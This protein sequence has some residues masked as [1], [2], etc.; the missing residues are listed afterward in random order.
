MKKTAISLLT[1]G[2]LAALASLLL[3]AGAASAATPSFD[4]Y[5]VAGTSSTTLPDGQSVNVWGYSPTNAPVSVPG[6]PTLYANVGDT[7]T[8]TLHNE[9]GEKTALLFQGQDMAPDL[10]GV[11]DGDTKVYTLKPT[12]PGTYLYEA[13]LTNNA[14]HQVAMGLYGA[15]VVRP[16]TAGQAYG[17]A[18]AYD[19]E[20]VLVL[21]E[22][23]PAL[24]ASADP[25]SFD[26]R[27]YSPKYFL[28][29]GK[30]Y[31]STAE[32][33]TAAGNKVLLRYVNAGQQYH[34]MAVLGARQNLVALDGNPLTYPR[35]A[36]AET[37]GPG[38]TADTILTAPAASNRQ[39]RLAVYDGSLLLHNSN[40]AGYG[41]M[42]TYVTIPS[43]PAP[44]DAGPVT[45]A[46]AYNGT[47][48]TATVVD[49]GIGAG[50]VAGAEY[51]V[52]SV[53]GT[54]V[55]M[56]AVDGTFD[57]VSENVTIAGI[58]A[59][60]HILYV[61]GKDSNGNLGVFSSVLVQGADT[62]GP[63]TVNATLNPN[64]TN[65]QTDVIVHA[66]ADD[67]ASG[68]SAVFAA[69][70]TIDAG[71]PVGMTVN[72]AAPIASVDGV[73]PAGT[74]NGLSP[75][76]H[77]VSI[78][79]RDSASTNW[80]APVT[81]NLVVDKTAPTTTIVSIAPN[82]NNGTKPINASTQAV[83][84]RVQLEDLGGATLSRAEAFIDTVGANGAGIVVAAD[85]GLF[86]SALETGYM[87]IPLTTVIQLSNGDHTI[88]V[89]AK[90]SAGNWGDM[91]TTT[92]TID[93]SPPSI[94][95]VTAT[96]NPTGTAT[97]VALAATAQADFTNVV[98]AEWFVG[99][100]PG[101][102]NGQAMAVSGSGPWSLSAS[103][104]VASW[105]PGS[106]SLKVRARDAAGNW[107]SVGTAALTVSPHP[108]SGSLFFS[109][110]G[111]ASLPGLGGTPDDADIYGWSGAAYSRA[112]DASAVGLPGGANV[113]A[114]HRV[115]GSHFYLSFSASNTSVPGLGNVQDEDVVYFNNGIWSVFF[116]GTAHGLT[117]TGE[118]ID[119]ITVDGSTLYFSTLGNVNPPNVGGGA[120]DADIYS[121]NGS[122]YSRVWDA[123]ANGLPGNADVDG[124]DR[125]DGSHLY[126][127]FTAGS[128]AVPSLGSVQDE[129]VVYRNG[130][131]WSVYFDGTAHGLGGNGALD[132][133]A[134]DVP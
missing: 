60:Q 132:V 62:T 75:G 13:G 47:N 36:V 112:V 31:P 119:A 61:R 20:A 42:L 113:D 49:D 67:T 106:Y 86:N 96:P 68:G 104:D 57:E 100:D 63:V 131:T 65:G 116:N 71:T 7:V 118:D 94:S 102:G 109:T 14:E 22:I 24:N 105:N 123:S 11:V 90:D 99:A 19:T 12:R 21:S 134:L 101:V 79:S 46:V 81:V 27:N 17:T 108:T 115:D 35:D 127:S 80:G 107:S 52:D 87:D 32:I 74:I 121:W 33:P 93:K 41:G 133:D 130:S 26:M 4:L 18:T 114:Y 43:L 111:S 82:P 15:L 23:D 77:V 125:V 64:P 40:V 50:H 38:Q 8:V 25:A 85:D 44:G 120:D 91:A 55:A 10:D 122:S 48:L 97:N 29:N 92:L 59:G 128:T 66:T 110:L 51:Y 9:L 58:P 30:A 129:D 69:E 37:F 98:A 34:S 76:T 103:I 39:T 73:I 70:Y 83:R 6:G 78:H 56:D 126:L 95:G 54:A 53:T 89:H 45:S 2:G 3:P 117:S 72:V 5:A 28:I 84:T 1:V 16:A 88:Y 124:M